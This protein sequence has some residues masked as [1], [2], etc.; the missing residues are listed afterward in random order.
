MSE[1]RYSGGPAEIRY[2][3]DLSIVQS[4]KEGATTLLEDIVSEYD[5]I[6]SRRTS[7]DGPGNDE[8]STD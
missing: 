2:H 6:S 7:Q 4:P 8:R 5:A 1:D 3:R